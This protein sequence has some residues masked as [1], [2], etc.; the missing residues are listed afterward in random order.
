[1]IRLNNICTRRPATRAS[2]G[3]ICLGVMDEH[4]DAQIEAR[5]G[6]GDRSGTLIIILHTLSFIQ[7]MRQTSRRRILKQT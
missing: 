4:L 6:F 7:R 5:D 1:M 2:I 3:S